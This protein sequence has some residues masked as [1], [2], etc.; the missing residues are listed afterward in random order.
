MGTRGAWALALA[1]GLFAGGCAHQSKAIPPPGNDPFR[2]GRED[3]LDIAVWRD[4]DLS[5][6]LPV[7]PDGFI[8]M[9]MVGD[10]KAEG[11]TPLELAERLRGSLQAYVLD[12]KVTVIVREVNSSRVFVTGEVARPGSYPLRGRMSLLQAVALAGGF[13]AFADS[14]GMVLLRVGKNGG[15]YPVRY[16]DLVGEGRRGEVYLEPGDTVVVP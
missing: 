5:R 11:L 8:S 2:I 9:P 13:T 14:D 16:S 1:A 6:V 3:V 4:A 7:R 12:P 10:V 15:R